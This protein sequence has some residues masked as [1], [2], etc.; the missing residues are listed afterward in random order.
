MARWA[1][2]SQRSVLDMLAGDVDEDGSAR[3]TPG[4]TGRDEA[5]DGDV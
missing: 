1:K 2:T 3:S 5:D 4:Q